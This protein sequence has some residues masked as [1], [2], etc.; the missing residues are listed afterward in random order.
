MRSTTWCSCLTRIS[1][2][3]PRARA[4]RSSST[5]RAPI[6]RQLPDAS[7]FP[8]LRCGVSRRVSPAGAAGRPNASTRSCS[9]IARSPPLLSGPSSA[10]K[11]L[12]ASSSGMRR[13]RAQARCSDRDFERL[14]DLR[15][16]RRDGLVSDLAGEF[17]QCLG[18]RGGVVET[19]AGELALQRHH[20]RHGLGGGERDGE[21]EIGVRAG[22]SASIALTLS[23]TMPLRAAP[24]L[25]STAAVASSAAALTSTKFGAA[26]TRLFSASARICR[27]DPGRDWRPLR[28]LSASAADSPLQR[29]RSRDAAAVSTATGAS[30]ASSWLRAL[31]GRAASAG[32]ARGVRTP[33]R[34]RRSGRRSTLSGCGSFDPGRRRPTDLR[35]RGGRAG[36]TSPPGDAAFSGSLPLS[37][38]SAPLR[39][40]TLTRTWLYAALDRR[41]DLLG[42]R[43]QIGHLRL[44]IF[45]LKREGFL[46]VL[47][48]HDLQGEIERRVDVLL[49]E[50]SACE[51]TDLALAR[52]LALAVST[53]SA[54]F[55]ATLTKPSNALRACST[56]FCAKSR[57]STGTSKG[58]GH[59]GP[60]FLK[61]R[62]ALR[63]PVDSIA[64][65]LLHCNINFAS[66][67]WDLTLTRPLMC[68]I[69]AAA[70]KFFKSLL[71]L[72][73]AARRRGRALGRRFVE[74]SWS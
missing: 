11:V 13:R 70:R 59:N 68:A 6:C 20:F 66:H 54:V 32:A 22:F 65:D 47:G 55:W 16:E 72:R 14:G 35:G 74:V 63:R 17:R 1:R 30:G 37:K 67:Q 31:D 41:A 24:Q 62:L 4:A 7:P 21:V 50:L 26:L 29:L 57:M 42:L 48:L 33:G 52:M 25:A 61:A 64:H 27:A 73:R 60:R 3:G 2:G 51:L 23:A 43:L 46:R 19:L 34:G 18:L 36:E 38:F 49:G 28:R 69:G 8:P 53:A 10:K 56:L 5:S 58:V 12:P 45:A 9:C 40:R 39:F 71:R 15:L 44:Q